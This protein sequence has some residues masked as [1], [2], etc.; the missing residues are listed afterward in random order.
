MKIEGF[1]EL[2][3][4]KTLNEDLETSK[5][6]LHPNSFIYKCNEIY[7]GN[8]EP[9][10]LNPIVF[11]KTGSKDLLL[12]VGE[13]WSYGDSLSPYV[14]AMDKL[15]NIPYR[16]STVFGGKLASHF[17]SDLFLYTQPGN[18]NGN[19]FS[20]IEDVLNFIF[21][22]LKYEKVRLVMQLTS[23]GRDL[24]NEPKIFE[25]L[26][27]MKKNNHPILNLNDWCIEYDKLFFE[28]LNEI[29]IKYP[30][31]D[32]VLWKNFNEFFYKNRDYKFKVIE[33]PFLRYGVEFCGEDVEL[34]MNYESYFFEVM[35]KIYNLKITND[36]VLNQ[37]NLLDTTF[38]KLGLSTLNNW[39]PNDGGHWTLATLIREKFNNI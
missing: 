25:H 31:Y 39:H 38:K 9:N 14:K 5:K 20:K 29:I 7:I 30:I 33:T 4:Y 15:D 36:E 6:N 35:E 26:F 34:P 28:R 19:Y 1:L 13:S 17:K 18:A 8:Y 32:T 24:Y 23:P 12:V 3:K 16:V 22:D 11:C 21:N 10:V 27:S 2:E 37:I